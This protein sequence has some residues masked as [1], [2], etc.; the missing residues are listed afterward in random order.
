MSEEDQTVDVMVLPKF[1][2]PFYESTMS[3]KDVKCLAIR[4]DIPLDLHPCALIEGWTM[5]QLPDDM[6]GLYEQ[7]FE[8]SGIRVPFSTLLLAVIKHFRIHISQLVPKQRHW[9]SFEKRVGKGVGGKRH[10]DSDV[11]DLVLKDGFNVL[12]VQALTER[13]IDLR[14]VPSGLL[15]K[16][17]LATTWD[18]PGFHLI[19]KDTGGNVVTM[20]KYLRFPL[21]LD[22]T[23]H[24]K[25]VEVEDPKIVA[26]REWKA[27]VAAKNKGDKK[28]DGDAREGSRPKVKRRKV[29]A[30]RRDGSAT[31]EHVYS[32]EPIRM[33]DPTRLDM[34]NP[35]ST[36]A[37]TAESCED[38]SLHIPPHDSAND[39]VHNYTKV[40]DDNDETNNLRLGS[41]ADQ[42]R[43]DLNAY[44]T[45]VFLSSPSSHSPL[46]LLLKKFLLPQ[47]LFG[48]HVEEGESSYSQALYVPDWTIPWRCRVDSLMWCR[49]LMVHLAPAAAQEESNALTNAVA[50]ERAC[51][52]KLAEAYAEYEVTVQKLVTARVDLEL[53]AKLYNDIASRYKK[54][55][56]AKMAKKDSTLVYAEGISAERAE[57]KE[58]LVTQLGRTEMKKFDC[59]RKL[60]PTVGLAEERSKNDIMDALLRFEDFEPYSDKKLYSMYDK[61]FKM[62]YPYIEN[63]ARGFRHSVAELL[64][65]HPNPPPPTFVCPKD[66]GVVHPDFSQ[67]PV[68]H[69]HRFIMDDPNI[70]MKNTSDSKKKKAQRHAI[71]FDDTFDETLLCE[72]TVSPLNNNEINFKISFD[73]SDDEDYMVIFD[74]N[75]FSY[76]IISVDNL[77][78][79]L[80]NEND[81]VNMPSS[82]SPEPMI[83]Y[84]DDLDFFKDFENEFLAIAYNN[85][86]KSKSDPLIEP[87]V[88]SRHIDKFDSKNE[89]SL[90]EYVEE[91]QNVLYF[92]DSFPLDIWHLYNLRIRDTHGLDFVGLTEGMRQTLDDRLKMVYTGDEG[93]ELFTSHAWR[94]LFEIRE[95]LGEAR[96]R[97]TWRQFILAL[98]L[99][100]EE[101]MEQAGFGAYWHGSERVIPDK[102]DLR[103]YW[104]EISFDRDF[105]GPAPSYVFIQ[106]PVRRLCHRMIACS[107][108]GKGQAPKKGLRGLSMV[109]HE[110]SLIDLHE[111]GRLNIYIKVGDTWAWVS[112]GPERQPDAAAGAPGSTE[113]APAVDEGAQADPAPVQ[114]PQPS[115][116]APRTMHQRISR[117]EEEV[118]TERCKAVRRCY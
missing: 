58:K 100:T 8:F 21:F 2:M 89:T 97:M 7:Y 24:Q 23:D 40:D 52:D 78:T 9:F 28:R 77:K 115:P 102:G 1:D 16:G 37:E 3:A 116:P 92:N 6:I 111:L 27:Q 76:K 73:E 107:I 101:E 70:T 67:R 12:D 60:L 98:G 104:M 114:A 5:D 95:P 10:H 32:P 44:K 25:E 74:E 118:A 46:A 117:L 64:K 53:N 86:L 14:Y 85:D 105:L 71:V 66:F 17:G 31:S 29:P 108:S 55:L 75:S 84:I 56:E 20:P 109:T 41:F 34:R 22:K 50:L 62:Q 81:K 18:F 110:L 79:D 49:E 47:K 93:Q 69:G 96:R 90:S 106:D 39:S 68:A 15:F 59:V 80:E 13:F 112:L 33:V 82:L 54:E 11:N 51:Y 19:F 72:P 63:I 113:D 61:L 48:I 91:E 99:H 42:T 94:R 83:G 57:E 87:S 65:V 35:P 38:R 4:H 45:E 30:A 88:S 26:T 43:K 36:G 103:D